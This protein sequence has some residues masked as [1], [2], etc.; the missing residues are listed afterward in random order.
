MAALAAGLTVFWMTKFGIPVSTSQAIIGSIIGWNLFSDSYTDISSLLKILSTWIICPLLAAFIAA[1]LYT[2]AKLF[3]R[4]IGTGLIRMDG[5]TR[6]RDYAIANPVRSTCNFVE[7][8]NINCSEKR[9]HSDT[10]MG[11]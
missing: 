9:N 1:L 8:S 7:L 11:I 2:T 3:V 5:Y 4:K 10:S 6:I